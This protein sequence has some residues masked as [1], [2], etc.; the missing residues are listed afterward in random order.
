MKKT[1]KKL[2]PTIVM[3]LVAASM[4]GTSTFAWFSMNSKVTVTGMT[5][6]TKLSNNLLIS[7]TNANDGT[8]VRALNQSRVA[9]LE[10][11]STVDGLSFWF[12]EVTNVKGTG[13]AIAENKYYEYSE[14]TAQEHTAA[15]KTAYDADFN[16][17][18][19]I[20]T[21][22]TS[23]VAYAYIDYVFYLKG[24]NAT[25][26]AQ[27]I[28]VNKCNLLYNGAAVTDKAWRVAFF[29]QNAVENNTTPAGALQDGDRKIILAPD[30]AA[31]FTSGKAVSAN[32]APSENVKNYGTFI[33]DS[34]ASTDVRAKLKS[35][36]ANAT[37]RIKV[38]VR[39][40][41]EGEDTTCKNDTYASLTSNWQ[42]DL[43]FTLDGNADE[44]TGAA[45]AVWKIGSA[46]NA[47]ATASGDTGTVTLTA[48]GKLSNGE[49][50]VSYVWKTA[51]GGDTTG[52][53]TATDNTFTAT[54]SGSYYCEITT[55]LGNVYRT[56]VVSLTV[57]TP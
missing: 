7:E 44:D 32:A 52:L 38:T 23:N 35:V 15:G 55:D 18:Y 46:A 10:P 25:N 14:T 50:P 57:T 11:A 42:L 33:D 21:V 6:S 29:V 36:A 56:N 40:W 12:T 41:L 48:G 4:V 20:G 17:N 16:S 54:T 31:Y 39:L 1:L 30:S 5:V 53:G 49:V 22:S 45:G 47:V 26:E 43:G 19:L 9:L 2:I 3:V 27:Y 28:Y 34:D 8:Y 24:T 51:N 37:D 13:E